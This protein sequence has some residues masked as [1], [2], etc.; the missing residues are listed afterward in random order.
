MNFIA[1]PTCAQ[2]IRLMREF[3]EF[4]YNY[5]CGLSHP[6][7]QEMLHMPLHSSESEPDFLYRRFVEEPVQFIRDWLENASQSQRMSFLA[8]VQS[9]VNLVDSQAGSTLLHVVE[10][11]HD[12]SP[13]SFV[14]H[15]LPLLGG[16][17]VNLTPL[18]SAIADIL[19]ECAMAVGIPAMERRLASLEGESRQYLEERLNGLRQR[20][21]KTGT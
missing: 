19:D 5:S 10:C 9:S 11:W 13:Q 21:S 4:Y 17:S 2:A 20:L 18:E 12:Y 16:T 7:M 15:L 8:C 1:A 3:E 6:Y 14:E